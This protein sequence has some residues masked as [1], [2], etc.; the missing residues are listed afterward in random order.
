LR[1]ALYVAVLAFVEQGRI[2][3]LCGV[4]QA[5]HAVMKVYSISTAFLFA[6]RDKKRVL[7]GGFDGRIVWDMEKDVKSE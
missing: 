7:R 4:V 5:L 6:L 3:E 2:G 1:E